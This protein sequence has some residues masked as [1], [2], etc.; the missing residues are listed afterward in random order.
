MQSKQMPFLSQHFKFLLGT[1]L[2]FARPTCFLHCWSY[3]FPCQSISACPLNFLCARGRNASCWRSQCKFTQKMLLVLCLTEKLSA[4]RRFWRAGFQV[5]EKLSISCA[6]K[7]QQL[8]HGW[9]RSIVLSETNGSPVDN[10]CFV[11]FIKRNFWTHSDKFVTFSF[12]GQQSRTGAHHKRLPVTSPQTVESFHSDNF[13]FVS[14]LVQKQWRQNSTRTWRLQAQWHVK[15][16][17]VERENN[18][19][20]VPWPECEVRKIARFSLAICRS[21][22]DMC[23]SRFDTFLSDIWTPDIRVTL[24]C[25]D[26]FL[27]SPR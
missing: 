3:T 6:N 20:P 8:V 1:R 2:E 11:S 12:S 9:R 22:S 7:L 16:T 4:P 27:T 24:A 18:F 17:V 25:Q 10:E 21:T 19:L 26:S 15:I 23:L 14:L 13:L 5:V